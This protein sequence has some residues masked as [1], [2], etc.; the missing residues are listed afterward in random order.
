MSTNCLVTKLKNTV[1]DPDYKLRKIG[2]LLIFAKLGTGA[3]TGANSS[4]AQT[5][6]FRNSGYTF[7]NN[8]QPEINITT[9]QSSATGLNVSAQGAV[10]SIPNR[11][12]LTMLTLKNGFIVQSLDE[13]K[14]CNDLARL[15]CMDGIDTVGDISVIAGL[16]SLTYI[17][18][19]NFPLVEGDIASFKDR[20]DIT[21][22]AIGNMP[23]LTGNISTLRKLVSLENLNILADNLITGTLESLCEGMC[24]NNRTSGTLT[25]RINRGVTFHGTTYLG[26]VNFSIEFS[27][28]GCTVTVNGGTSTYVKA[29]GTWTYPS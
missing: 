2:E 13:F 26:V 23:K 1:S 5:A 18:M 9:N 6:S 24:A 7:V 10:I 28:T 22:I 21:S 8:N 14:M 11:Y 3:N 17:D 16:P 12:N 29:T 4:V 15:I 19:G 25:F 20:T 27:A